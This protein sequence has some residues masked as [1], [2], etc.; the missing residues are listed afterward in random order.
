MEDLAGK[1]A[2]VRGG[3]KDESMG[4]GIARAF[5]AAGASIVLVGASKRRLS[6][7]RELASRFGVGLLCF[8]DVPEDEGFAQ[9]VLREV[10]DRFGRLDVLVNATLVAKPAFLDEL[11]ATDLRSSLDVNLV[12]PFLWMR[13]C[14]PHLA[15][16]AGLVINLGS[17]SASAGMA[18]CGALAAASM[19]LLGLG[20]VAAREWEPE[21][22]RVEHL[23][24]C[25]STARADAW[26]REFPEACEEALRDVALVTVDEVGAR[27]V[28]LARE[29]L[30][31]CL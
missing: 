30:G 24:A 26:A 19:G 15:R 1:V 31:G 12:E 27:C 18:A 28:A 20:R 25:A 14:Q 13:A 3:G 7:A 10:V 23:A 21:G 6:E 11:D 8:Q 5:A 22:V 2:L 17:E 9:L 16:S 29:H 4:Y